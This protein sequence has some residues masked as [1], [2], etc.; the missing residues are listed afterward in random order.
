MK[1]YLDLDDVFV[2]PPAVASLNSL[3]I[4]GVDV[5]VAR[6]SSYQHFLVEFD[7]P[8]ER[9]VIATDVL[10]IHFHSSSTLKMD[11]SW[12][13]GTIFNDVT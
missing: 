1:F 13:V 10:R 2:A 4:C 11:S 5:F 8:G 7:R 6:T 9:Q 12:V 3:L